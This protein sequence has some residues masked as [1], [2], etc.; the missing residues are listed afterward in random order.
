MVAE[1]ETV[2]ADTYVR[3]VVE[4]PLLLEEDPWDEV[5]PADGTWPAERENVW[6]ARVG[7]SD[8]G[9]KEVVE[10]AFD[11]GKLHVFDPRT[12]DAVDR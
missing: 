4:A 8:P 10:L 2:G 7:S 6:V 5:D 9:A 12:G 11:P 1:R 3:F